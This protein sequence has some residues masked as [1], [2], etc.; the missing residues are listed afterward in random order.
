[1]YY[2]DL[3]IGTINQSS[4]TLIVQLHMKKAVEHNADRTPHYSNHFSRIHRPDVS[5]THRTKEENI[6]STYT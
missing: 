3:I 4:Q 2:E 5:Q 6:S 1:M